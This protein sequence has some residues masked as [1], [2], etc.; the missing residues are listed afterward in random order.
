MLLDEP[1]HMTHRKFMLP[2][3][4]G[5]RMRGYG[6]MMSMVARREIAT[7]PIAEPFALWPRM[8]AISMEVVMRAV[9]G[10]I[11]TE[12]LKR[13][14]T[15]LKTLTDW[16]NDPRRLTLLSAFG[17]RW[18]S[19]NVGFQAVMEPVE[20]AVLE[21]VRRRRAQG[22]RDGDDILSLL[23]QAYDESGAPMS[24]Q[25]VRDELITLLSDGPTSTSLAWSFERLLRHPEKLA[26]LRAEVLDGEDETYA[27]R[28][29]Q[30][31]VAPVPGGPARDAQARSADGVRRLHDPRGCDRRPVRVPDSPP[32]GHIPTTARVPAR[33]VPGASGWHLHLDSLW[34]R[35]AP[36]RRREL[37]PDGDEAGDEDGAQL[38]R[39]CD[40]VVSLRARDQ[41]CDRVHAES[42]RA[43]DGN[44][45]GDLLRTTFP[46]LRSEAQTA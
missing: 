4:H 12:Q 34:R 11:E 31:D 38:G 36:L 13:V 26:R 33:A 21:E 27:G 28:R 24:E 40:R 17:P 23:E 14:R 43:R 41:K 32:R 1:E 35:G 30:R 19:R 3:F 8:Q 6:E 29:R 46:E 22:A 16:L 5:E 42:G 7:W 15:L 39:A 2:S 44:L 9:F 37:C 45:A 20:S 18:L 10:D 25:E